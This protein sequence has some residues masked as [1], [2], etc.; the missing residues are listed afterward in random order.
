[1]VRG[2]IGRVIGLDAAAEAK[3]G[4]GDL[5]ADQLNAQQDLA[6]P[7]VVAGPMVD[8]NRADDPGPGGRAGPE[9]RSAPRPSPVLFSG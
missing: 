2:L 9:M 7:I 1:M 6:G 4:V 5:P 3:A 8:R